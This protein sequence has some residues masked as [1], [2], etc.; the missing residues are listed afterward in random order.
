MTRELGYIICFLLLFPL[1]FGLD[2]SIF[3]KQTKASDAGI[4]L[5]KDMVG[6]VK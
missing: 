1:T 3:H 2:H 4:H 5:N 6:K